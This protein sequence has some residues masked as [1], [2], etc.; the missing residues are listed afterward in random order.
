MLPQYASQG[1]VL[2]ITELA[3][4][5]GISGPKLWNEYSLMFNLHLGKPQL[6]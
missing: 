3:D 5:F 4:M 2:S 1:N 6:H